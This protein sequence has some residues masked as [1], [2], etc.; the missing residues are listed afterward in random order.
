[1]YEQTGTPK[2]VFDVIWTVLLKFGR[3]NCRILYTL[4][5][6]PNTYR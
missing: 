4:I 6:N 2:K 3:K 5:C 1:M